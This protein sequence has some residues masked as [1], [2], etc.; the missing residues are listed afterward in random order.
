MLAYKAEMKDKILSEAS[1]SAVVRFTW[2]KPEQ[3]EHDVFKV[4]KPYV[5]A[6]FSEDMDL[7]A[8]MAALP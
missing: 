6:Y 1:V 7:L 3:R 2:Y 8:R 5:A 4:M